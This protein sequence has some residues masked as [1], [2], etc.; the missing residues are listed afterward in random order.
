[1]PVALRVLI[2][3]SLAVAS[4]FTLPTV[5]SQTGHLS[6][7]TL[8][9]SY[10]VP[11]TAF[12]GARGQPAPPPCCHWWL[13]DFWDN[14]TGGFLPSNLAGQFVAVPNTISGLQ[15]GDA[16][17]YLP[18][19]VAYG[20]NST[21]CVWFQFDVNF[22]PTGGVEWYIWDVRCPGT[23]TSNYPSGDY[24]ATALGIPYTSGDHYR[25]A[26]TPSGSNT[27]TFSINDTT[28][29]SSWSKDNWVW[30]VPS[31][32]IVGNGSTF[33]P[34][35]AVEGY[36][37]GSQLNG[38]PTFRTM[39]GNGITT[40]RNYESLT[41][42]PAGIRTFR[43]EIDS[44]HWNWGMAEQ[45]CG[46]VSSPGTLNCGGID[47]T[48]LS[49][50][51]GKTEY[52]SCFGYYQIQES[53]TGPTGTWKP[54]LSQTSL[55]NTTDLVQS[56]VPGKTYWWREVDQ[57]N[58]IC[59]NQSVTTNVLQTTQPNAAT[60]SYK[61]LSDTHYTF[62]WNNLA[63]YNGSLAFH[64]YQLLEST[65]QGSYGLIYTSV[66]NSTI[67]FNQN[68]APNTM[69]SLYLITVDRCTACSI[70]SIVTSNSSPVNLVTP[71]TLVVSLVSQRS[72]VDAG[73]PV[74]LSCT[75]FG[76]VPAYNYTWWFGDGSVGTGQFVS[77]TYAVEYYELVYGTIMHVACEVGDGLNTLALGNANVTVYPDPALSRLTIDPSAVDSGQGFIV[78]ASASSGTG[79]YTFS[80][81]APQ[82]CSTS[83]SDRIYCIVTVAGNYTAA[84][85]VTDSNG[86]QVFSNPITIVVHPPPVIDSFTASTAS[87]DVGQTMNF[88]VTASGGAQPFSYYY[89]SLPPGCETE[90]KA[91]L[92]CTPTSGGTFDVEVMVEDQAG[93]SD[94]TF[95]TIDV[96][97]P[98]QILGVPALQFSIA[99][100]LAIAAFV[101]IALGAA[102]AFKSG[103]SGA[104][105][106][107]QPAID[108]KAA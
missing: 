99:T 50:N 78:S 44:S 71:Q 93:S 69:Y 51:W 16:I 29:G 73:Q 61:P 90:N 33:S 86:F 41:G 53:T 75:A 14:S 19:N 39:L 47:P 91:I 31:T 59:F 43:S 18:L 77:H 9:L 103:K 46:P 54:I 22:D 38:V 76:G 80:W 100:G 8:S 105:K 24:H 7:N 92:F 21:N 108:P 94:S 60:L 72:L 49:L 26:I 52:T 45:A 57:A 17:L 15:L 107:G 85:S 98:N 40:N 70:Q 36:T 42:E 30:N 96:S 102:S 87:L 74:S 95:V 20:T 12:L 55:T 35:S 6:S 48:A 84:A 83:T 28:K 106:S 2:L 64:E 37:S 97:Q 89:G 65:N 104:K 67:S 56:L 25:F 81:T 62:I 88:T 63:G 5:H 66:S 79:V 10:P 58:G 101:A 34:S 82:G 27:I 11:P 23:N 3:V 68:L 32:N 13:F 1:M 4:F